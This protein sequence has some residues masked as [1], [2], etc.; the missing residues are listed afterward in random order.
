[1]SVRLFKTNDSN[2]N[3]PIPSGFRVESQGPLKEY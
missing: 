2:K 3:T 1:M